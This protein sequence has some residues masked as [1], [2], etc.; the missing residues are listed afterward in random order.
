M[1]A[2]SY[3]IGKRRGSLGQ[4]HIRA[5]PLVSNPHPDTLK[6]S[7][8]PGPA[9]RVL[10]LFGVLR[11]PCLAQRVIHVCTVSNSALKLQPSLPLSLRLTLLLAV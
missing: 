2:L 1:T 6:A 7:L 8:N 9:S 10:P 11:P 5:Q 3:L 4:P